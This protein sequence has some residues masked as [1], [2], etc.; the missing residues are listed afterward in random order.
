MEDLAGEEFSFTTAA[1]LMAT[2]SAYMDSGRPAS[3]CD[4]L[5]RNGGNGNTDDKI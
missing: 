5:S 3:R 2:V 4:H 1:V